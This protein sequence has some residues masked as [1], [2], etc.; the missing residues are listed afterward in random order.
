MLSICAFKRLFPS[1][2]GTKN[3]AAS[4]LIL[5]RV[6][7]LYNSKSPKELWGVYEQIF[8]PNARFIDPFVDARPR[9]EAFLQFAALHRLFEQVKVQPTS[10]P[11]LTAQPETEDTTKTKTVSVE[12]EFEYFWKRNG[13]FSR[14]LLPEMTLVK[15]TVSLLL[16]ETGERVLCHTDTWH[17]P[18]I[19]LPRTIK[20]INTTVSNSIFRLF[21]WGDKS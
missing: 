21:G 17:E 4:I 9:E 7:G 18:S 15:A 8:D 11:C 14:R 1:M 19:E 16:D 3:G 5:T 20:I 12:C 2:E 13:F 6:L 10:S